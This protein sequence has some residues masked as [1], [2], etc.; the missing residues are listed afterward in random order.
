MNHH[1]TTIAVIV[2]LI[3]VGFVLGLSFYLG[4]KA[5]S[6]KGYY[7]AHGGVHWFIN[8]IAFAGDYLSAASFLGICGL[9]ATFGYDGFLYSIGYLAGWV[10]A[11]FVIAEPLKR[12]GRFTFADALDNRFNSRGI[13]LSAAISTL[14]VSLFYLIPQMVGAGALVKPLLGLEHYQGVL[15]VG[16]IVITI[17]VTAGM[18]STTYVQFIKGSMLVIFCAILTVMILYRGLTTK[19]NYGDVNYRPFKTVSAA[20]LRGD[21]N[22]KELEPEGKW[23]DVKSLVRFKD[24]TT[25]A[26]SIWV[27][28]DAAGTQLGEAQSTFIKKISD[29]EQQTFTNGSVVRNGKPDAGEI[30]AVGNIA[31]LPGGIE[32]TGPLGPLDYF[33]RFSESK[34]AVWRSEVV[35]VGDMKHA[36]DSI[37]TVYYP[38]ITAGDELLKPGNYPAF[39]GI[40]LENK[41]ENWKDKANFISLM[42]ALFCGT[43]SLPHILIRYYTVK[44]QASA[45]KSTVVGIASIGFFYILTLYLGLGAM[46]SGAMDVTD[47]NMSAPLL[48]K[49]FGALPFAVIS[50]IAFTTV[51]GTVSGLII[52]ASG[53]VAHDL[54]TNFMKRD[55]NDHEKVRAGKFA[56]VVVGILAMILG[57]IF[58]TF[59]VTF[60]VGWAFNVAASANLPALVMLLF[61][62]GTTK[63]GI[64]VGIFAGLLTSLVWILLSGDAYKNLYGLP[65]AQAIAPF[66]QPGL[67]TI[68]L[69]FIVL[70][71]VSL[72]TKKRGEASI[73]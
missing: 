11:L 26:V 36:G 42:L 9:I 27:K 71:V 13:K 69:G 62:K 40:K 23:K 44:D 29:D 34:I 52:A 10:V 73:A 49:T 1:P 33:R 66:N 12:L 35:K 54:M 57:I 43:A 30:F 48:A 56:A 4:S 41:I 68:P 60:L 24:Q 18:V 7:A 19:P 50:A 67:V 51:L 61:W 39:K 46:T 15:I 70:I 14:V 32:S 55:L 59:N 72:L 31:Q 45:R 8:G 16:A 65:E 28:L 3:F 37:T 64:T 53:A 47:T 25:G 63:Q 5:K 2:F 38:V 21:A 58:K 22:L 20:A 17:V 6:A